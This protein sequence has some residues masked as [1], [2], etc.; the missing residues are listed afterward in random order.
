MPDDTRDIVIQLRA[1]VAAQGEAIAAMQRS[2]QTL[3][4]AAEREKGQ[5]S[6]LMF[7]GSIMLAAAGAVG[8][9]IKGWTLGIYP[10]PK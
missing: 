9:L 5:R 6:V 1:Q 3:E 7:L 4:K 2:L 8:A 10:A